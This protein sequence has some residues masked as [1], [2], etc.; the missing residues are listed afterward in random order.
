MNW[1]EK[2]SFL[3]VEWY[4][5]AGVVLAKVV[6]VEI[7]GF[8][9]A[10]WLREIYLKVDCLAFCRFYKPFSLE[11]GEVK[12]KVSDRCLMIDS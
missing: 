7:S 5:T 12:T 2:M 9:M 8:P 1:R 6:S 3:A 11:Q 10:Y 4:S